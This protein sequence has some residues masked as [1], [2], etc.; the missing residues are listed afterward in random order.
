MSESGMLTYENIRIFMMFNMQ[1]IIEVIEEDVVYEEVPE[2]HV[3]ETGDSV[4]VKQVLDDAT[5]EAVKK[6]G[7]DINYRAENIKLFIMFISCVFALVA[8][9][10]PLTFPDSRMLLGICCAAY[11]ILS[12]ILQF[13]VTFIDKDS[14]IISQPH[15]VIFYNLLLS[16]FNQ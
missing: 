16:S 12:T 7:Y 6:Y 3:I 2:P 9:F 1:I 10:Y 8:Q 14:I 5:M 4:K 13:I 11:F 15:K